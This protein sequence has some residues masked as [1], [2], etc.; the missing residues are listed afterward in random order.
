MTGKKLLKFSLPAVTLQRAFLAHESYAVYFCRH[1]S[2][3]KNETG[4]HS[5]SR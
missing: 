4:S 5:D 1:K 2:D 3:E